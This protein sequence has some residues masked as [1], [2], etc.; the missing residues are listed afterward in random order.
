MKI[1][2]YGAGGVGGYFG[3]RLAQAGADVHL[4][5]RGEHLGTLRENSLDVESVHGDFSVDLPAT[6]DPADI[7]ECDV[8]LFCVKSF[9][10]RSAARDLDPLL[11]DD[12]AVLSLQNGVENEDHLAGAIGR[13]HV[14]GGVA[15]I[16][17]T[18]GDPGV[19]EHTDGPARI[20]YGELDGDR[21]D[22]AERFDEL[23]ARAPG[24][25]GVLSPEIRTELWNKYTFIAAMSGV[26]AA[27][28]LPIG[29]IRESD[30]SWSLFVDLIEEASDVAA[31]EGIHV[32]DEVIEEWIA[33]ARDLEYDTYS[34][35]H[36]DMTNGKRMELE[37]LLG[38]V[39]RTADEHGVDV[40][41]SRTV[42]AILRPW[43][44]RNEK[45][46]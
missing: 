4:I 40:P 25:E 20:V 6:S 34:S 27:I 35:L 45:A 21:S 3:G 41:R 36:Y 23:C 44:A 42:Y 38:A 39:V 31:A 5:A 28:R 18:I 22:R 14:M 37:A 32:T 10:T 33:F 12:T 24:M 1:A 13:E 9:D 43:A 15:Y 29:A 30:E 17:S 26:T 16:F 11:G 2:V 8:V 19:I 7:G 46:G